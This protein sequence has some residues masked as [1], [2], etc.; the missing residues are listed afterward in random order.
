M[1]T[2]QFEGNESPPAVDRTE[3]EELDG[4]RTRVVVTS[5]LPS[6][7]ARDAM[8]A[9]GMEKGV[10]EGYEKLDELLARQYGESALG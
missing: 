4:G 3:L 6:S 8:L 10:R 1:Q 5:A 2:F 9:S 7:E